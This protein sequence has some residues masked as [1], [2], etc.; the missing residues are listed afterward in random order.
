MLC[1]VSK[2]GVKLAGSTL[3]PLCC[4]ALRILEVPTLLPS[5]CIAEV[6]RPHA[7][8]TCGI[9]RD[10]WIYILCLLRLM[11]LTLSDLLYFAHLLALIYETALFPS[12]GWGRVAWKWET[13]LTI[14]HT[15]AL[16]LSI[17]KSTIE[18]RVFDEVNNKERERKWKGYEKYWYVGEKLEVGGRRWSDHKDRE[19]WRLFGPGANRDEVEANC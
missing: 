12:K 3:L 18:T 8:L 6:Q 17:P 19:H 1:Y 10:T 16:M 4:S 2:R 9:S 13:F 7:D 11:N 15:K 14:S 5:A